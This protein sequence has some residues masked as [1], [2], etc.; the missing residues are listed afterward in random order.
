MAVEVLGFQ[1]GATHSLNI[2]RKVHE[3]AI[4]DVVCIPGNPPPVLRFEKFIPVPF[5]D[6]GVQEIPRGAVHFLNGHQW[7]HNFGRSP[8]FFRSF[9]GSELR[10]G[11]RGFSFL[12][13]RLF[14]FNRVSNRG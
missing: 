4:W 10:L 12:F 14:F 6:Q 5:A 1:N 13:L 8:G 3:R 7:C 11:F 2:V 9:G